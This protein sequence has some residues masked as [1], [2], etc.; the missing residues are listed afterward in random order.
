MKYEITREELEEIAC[1]IVDNNL[2]RDEAINYILE[3]ASECLLDG[4][5]DANS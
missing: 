5:E 1:C 2:S 4:I 3:V